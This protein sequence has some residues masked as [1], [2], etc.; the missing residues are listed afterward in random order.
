M[1]SEIAPFGKVKLHLE[2]D[3]S[4]YFGWQR[5][6]DEFPTIQGTIEQALEKLFEVK[7]SL[8]G[9]GRTDT[10]VHAI[11]QV[12]H[13]IPPRDIAHY[14]FQQAFMSL[15][16]NDI[17]VK[18]AE[19]APAHF[20][21]QRSA[22]RKTYLYRIWN[23][24]H[25]S[26]LHAKRAW[27]IRTPLDLEV[28][29][30]AAQSLVGEHDFRSLRS[31]GSAVQ[32]TIRT[33]YSAKFLKTREFIEFRVTGSGFLKQMVRNMVGTLIQI[34]LNHRAPGSLKPLLEARDRRL[35]G[36]TAPAHG[37]YME[38]V[39]YPPDLMGEFRLLDN[40]R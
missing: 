17:V 16:P 1:N 26:A 36:P 23:D 22:V 39:E 29:N 24:V 32:S 4:A 31:E 8:I 38:S 19:R 37:L 25:P 27:H 6:N 5:Q 34:P 21:A 14:N 18:R 15:L 20:H 40:R 2:Y 13:F 12:A 30:K 33:I 35:A 7:L 3:G 9:A 10:G 11:D 28:L